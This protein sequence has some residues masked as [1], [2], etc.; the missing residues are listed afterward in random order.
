MVDIAYKNIDNKDKLNNCLSKIKISSEHLNSLV[1]DVLD[2]SRIE[3]G[4]LHINKEPIDIKNIYDSCVAIID[5]QTKPNNLKFVHSMEDVKHTHV[6]GDALHIKEVM[7]NILGNALKFSKEDGEVKFIVRELSCENEMVKYEFVIEDNGIGMS[8]EF[9]KHIYE[10]FSQEVDS[11]RTVYKGTGLGMAIAKNYI[12]MMGGTIDLTSEINKGS[13]FIIN[14]EL[15][16]CNE[17][18]DNSIRVTDKTLKNITFLVAEDNEINME[19]IESV[20]EGENVKIIKAYNGKEALQL[21]KDS[22]ENEIDIILMDVM[23]PLMDGLEATK[24]IRALAREDA[25][26]IPII[27]M[28]ANVYESDVN[29]SLKAGMNAHLGKP[30]EVD[31]LYQLIK[32]FCV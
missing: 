28:S 9:Q 11:S 2:M 14:L 25:K 12:D 16:I 3:T 13:R 21:Y 29:K 1:N 23:M 10:S 8:K 22:K 7:I 6:Y 17:C 32:C 24:R 5:Y 4:K 20:L 18:V 30:I 15:P 26:T 27:A 31:K 19:I